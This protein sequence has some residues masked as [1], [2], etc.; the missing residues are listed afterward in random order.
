VGLARLGGLSWD[1]F[2]G[3]TAVPYNKAGICGF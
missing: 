2:Q 3:H 1:E